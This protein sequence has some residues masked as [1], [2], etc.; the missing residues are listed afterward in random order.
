M[1]FICLNIIKALRKH[2]ITTCKNEYN[3]NIEI[4]GINNKEIIDPKEEYFFAKATNIHIDI[5]IIPNK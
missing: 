4:K 5:K 1:L 3:K 2:K